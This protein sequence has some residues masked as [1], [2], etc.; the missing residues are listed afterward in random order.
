MTRSKVNQ[1]VFSNN[2]KPIQ[3]DDAIEILEKARA[4]YRKHERAG[5]ATREI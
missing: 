4:A 2:V 3:L 5:G 1:I